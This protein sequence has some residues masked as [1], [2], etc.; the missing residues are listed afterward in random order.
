MKREKNK[1]L[2]E[3]VSKND[4]HPG[5]AMGKRNG[6]QMAVNKFRRGLGI[7]WI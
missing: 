7:G 4:I 1:E 3:Y 2:I 6:D 5:L